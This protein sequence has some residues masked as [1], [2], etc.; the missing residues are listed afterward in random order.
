MKTNLATFHLYLLVL[1]VGFTA[2]S[3]GNQDSTDTSAINTEEMSDQG[4]E[5]EKI[6]EN[7]YAR[8]FSVQLEPGESLSPHEGGPRLIYSLSDYSIDWVENGE[9]EGT[10]N[11][12]QGDVHV[13]GE[14]MHAATN[15]GQTTAEWLAFVRK[16]DQ[17]PD[18][19]MQSQEE[20]MREVS[21]EQ[22]KV[23]YEDD[24]FKIAEVRLSAGEEIPMHEGVNRVIYSMADYTLAYQEE[25]EDMTQRTFKAGDVHWHDACNHSVSNPSD[26]SAHFLVVGYKE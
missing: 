25:G 26:N 20:A 6:F 24:M 23:L 17:L 11:W 19:E 22:V 16:S 5:P 21:E 18:C 13:H 15:N 3:S 2:C 12:K 14:G 10:K 4:I 9:Q 1:A 8:V 7:E